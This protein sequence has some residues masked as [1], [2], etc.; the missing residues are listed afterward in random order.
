[1][2]EYFENLEVNLFLEVGIPQI[3]SDNHWSAN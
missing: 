2:I 3:S 1:M